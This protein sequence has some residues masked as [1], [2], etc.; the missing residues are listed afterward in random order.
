MTTKNAIFISF[1][2][3]YLSYA[4]SCINSIFSNY[5]SH[6]VILINYAGRHKMVTD[7][8]VRSGRVRFLNLSNDFKFCLGPINNAIVYDRLLLWT[9]IFDE[10]DQILHLDVDTLVLRPLDEFFE[11]RRFHIISDNH[12][13]AR[14]LKIHDQ[15]IHHNMDPYASTHCT[16]LLEKDGL[17]SMNEPHKMGNAGVFLVTREH[18]EQ[19]QFILL[20]ELATRYDQYLA[21][22][23]QSVIAL[24]CAK[25]NIQPTQDFTF[26]YQIR[27]LLQGEPGIDNIHILHFSGEAKFYDGYIKDPAHISIYRQCD[28]LRLFYRTTRSASELQR[29]LDYLK[30]SIL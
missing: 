10:F 13:L 26:N 22:A 25:N 1:D 14:T 8:E 21:Y 3:N 2:D 7:D 23:D 30:N 20:I 9:D 29:Q 5:P 19:R 6:P 28:L 17:K 16:Q 27:F 24:W 11:S 15:R 4:K 18:R 12:P